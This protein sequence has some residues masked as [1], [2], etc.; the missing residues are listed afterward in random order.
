MPF[1][2]V[3]IYKISMLDGRY[4]EIIKF[5]KL[6]KFSKNY[7]GRIK[8]FRQRREILVSHRVFTTTVNNMK[9]HAENYLFLICV[10]YYNVSLM[11]A[12]I[13]L[14]HRGITVVLKSTWQTLSE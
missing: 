9:A 14:D 7:Y 1:I 4:K 12:G 3:C 10:L 13:G 8:A 5:W 6:I 2:C 11:S